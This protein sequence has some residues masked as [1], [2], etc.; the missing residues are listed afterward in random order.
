M[1][2][3]NQ[4]TSFHLAEIGDDGEETG[5]PKSSLLVDDDYEIPEIQRDISSLP[6]PAR[7]MR[8]LLVD[9]AKAG[10]IEKLANYIGT[11]DDMT[12][13]TLGGMDQSPVDFLK[14]MSGDEEGYEILAILQE[15]LEAG[16]VHL[17]KGTENEIYVWPYFYGIPIL[18]LDASQ[19]VELYKLMTHGDYEEMKNFG[20]YS[21]YR[22][23]I[24]PEGR[25][26]FFV[27]GD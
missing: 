18:D 7:K 10:D 25:W 23:G 5:Q 8:Q 2:F 11:G 22:V 3:E 24:T 21:F 19:R 17:D 14:S 6:F 26:R 4:A 12:M 9:A 15:V 1:N 20:A 27:A 16:Y 13:L